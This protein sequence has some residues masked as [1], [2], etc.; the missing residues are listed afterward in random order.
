M[1]A[2]VFS[3]AHHDHVTMGQPRA[4]DIDAAFN[5][6]CAE[7]IYGK[8]DVAFFLGDL[9]DPDE[10]A[11]VIQAMTAV[12][13]LNANLD[14][15][16]ILFVAIAGNHDVLEDG[17]GMTTLSPLRYLQPDC[18]LAEGPRAFTMDRHSSQAF[19]VVA[20]PFRA[21]SHAY[22]PDAF[23]LDILA[24]EDRYALQP[25]V[26]TFVI[27]HLAIPGVQPGEETKELAR[28]RETLFPFKA[29]GMLKER[30][31][32]PVVVMN[33]HYHRRQTF[34]PPGESYDIHIPGSMARLTMTEERHEPSYLIVEV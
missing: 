20:L 32:A 22:D 10:G 17:S 12:V 24:N 19:N 33:G 16:D 5:L 15:S 13:K 34:R 7:A 23:V 27:G 4:G 8:V 28:G 11:A 14:T 6:V 9:S 25:A 3:D 2:I 31:E 30:M 18:M 26:P 29:V 1:K 21:T